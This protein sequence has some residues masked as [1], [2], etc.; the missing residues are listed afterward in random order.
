M[1]KILIVGAGLSG[2]TCAAE[3]ANAGFEITVQEERSHIAGN[4]FDEYDSHGVLIHRYGPHIFHTN[5]IKVFDFLSQY[6]SWRRYEHK[7]LAKYKENY[8]PIPLNITSIGHYFGKNL[9]TSKDLNNILQPLRVPRDAIKS[10][11]DY[12]L[13]AIGVEL[14]DAFFSG[15]TKKQWGCGLEELDA[16]VAARVPF[17]DS[18][19]DRY[20]QDKYQGIPSDGY[21]AMVTRMLDHPRIKIE[22]NKKATSH[23]FGDYEH[24]IFTGA[25]DRLLNYRHGRLPY[26][27]LQFCFEHHPNIELFQPV[28]TINYPDI[29]DGP[30]TRVTEF[31]HLTGQEIDGTTV[32]REIS[33]DKG[34]PYYP[35]PTQANRLLHEIYV[36]DIS[37]LMP[38][39]HLVGRLA[40]YRYYNM[41]QAVASALAFTKRFLLQ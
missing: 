12:L 25:I 13:A 41:D 15:Y 4:T 32:V 26:R 33:T 9:K 5:S 17:R 19:D 14:T 31:K 28:G 34:D 23:D 40:E 21:T 7:V 6:T 36:S 35:I 1:N 30:E 18:V 10:S 29:A 39:V 22:L 3:L 8:F 11:E 2:A 16:S 27:S 24:I 38:K 37:H 20:F